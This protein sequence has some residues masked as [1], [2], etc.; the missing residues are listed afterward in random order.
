MRIELEHVCLG[1]GNWGSINIMWKKASRR[2][3]HSWQT[4]LHS[5]QLLLCSD[6]TQKRICVTRELS[7]FLVLF[8]VFRLKRESYIQ[9]SKIYLT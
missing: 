7:I 5:A 3:L 9:R 4:C 8:Q 6:E 2:D 1:G